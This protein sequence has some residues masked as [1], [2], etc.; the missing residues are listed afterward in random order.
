[1]S[2]KRRG[3]IGMLVL[4]VIQGVLVLGLGGATAYLAMRDRKREMDL[5][6]TLRAVQPYVEIK[7]GAE[8]PSLPD[9]GALPARAA[10]VAELKAAH[11]SGPNKGMP[12]L[13][14]LLLQQEELTAKIIGS[15]KDS[16]KPSFV[17]KVLAENMYYPNLKG[18]NIKGPGKVETITS[19][20]QLVHLSVGDALRVMRE[21]YNDL[22]AKLEQEKKNYAALSKFEEWAKAASA[23]EIVLDGKKDTLLNHV[24]VRAGGNDNPDATQYITAL[25][26]F[27]DSVSKRANEEAAKAKAA[28]DARKDAVKSLEEEKA[29]FASEQD[30]DRKEWLAKTTAQATELAD[31]RKA[32]EDDVKKLKEEYGK[33]EKVARERIRLTPEMVTADIVLESAGKVTQV[34]EKRK[35]VLLNIDSG[36]RNKVRPGYRFSIYPQDPAIVMN[37]ESLKGKVEVVSVNGNFAEAR[38]V[39][40]GRDQIINERDRIGNPFVGRPVRHVALIGYFDLDGDGVA[41][42]E[43]TQQLIDFINYK[44]GGRV[45]TDSINPERA[46]FKESTDFFCFGTVPPPVQISDK[47]T[48]QERKRAAEVAALNKQEKDGRDV[49]AKWAIPILN[50]NR[51]FDMIGIQTRSDDPTRR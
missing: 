24:K 6:K 29:K 48:D 21:N 25:S 46:E 40:V 12:V 23:V 32:H 31:E 30:K 20:Q 42:R 45:D 28:D 27:L 38:I 37:K 36:V 11:G 44:W 34:N 7:E 18:L 10:L 2:R 49:A 16:I 22:N 9:P 35:T 14:A 33:L 17:Y 15:S 1:M 19:A 13:N 8:S 41:T 39:E 4:V 50:Q 47:A 3:N 5:E 26:A 43:E 51:L